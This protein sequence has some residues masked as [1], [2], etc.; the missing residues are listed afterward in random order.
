MSAGAEQNE[1][2]QRTALARQRRLAG[3]L[4]LFMAAVYVGARLIPE[5]PFWL[6]L[7]RAA[8][9]A[10]LVGGLADW[11]AVTALFRHPF[12]I[13]IPHTAIIPRNQARI[14]VALGRFVER[15][16]L[17][18]EL[19]T[20][21]LRSLDLA[22]RLGSWL[23]EPTHAYRVAARITSALPWMVHAA[24][25][26]SLRDF[27]RRALH[28]QLAQVNLAPMLGGLLELLKAGGRHQQLFDRALVLGSELLA[29]NE[30]RV[31]ALISDKSRWWVPPSID[32]NIARRLI[33]ALH[34][35]LEELA[36]HEH[37]ARRGFDAATHDFI[38]RLKHS[39]ELHTRVEA[40][41]REL[42]DSPRMQEY[43]AAV[44]EEL[45]TRIVDDAAAPDS[46]ITAALSH[47]LAALGTTLMQ[48]DAVRA[49]VNRR[50]EGLTVDFAVP[51]R[52]EIGN[53]IA[54][55]V[56]SWDTATMTDR[57]ELIVGRDLQFIRIN[58]TLVGA[59]VGVLLFL[60][61]SLLFP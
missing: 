22:S 28:E 26:R 46:R 54:E 8:S 44:W 36:D 55:V 19:L 50:I 39:P 60:G 56:N 27:A 38:E 53:F 16:F 61:S 24:D 7:V 20:Q 35:L 5:A 43:F 37:E 11:F 9:E 12:G 25:D 4:L 48:D 18:P 13:P 40:L 17:E 14:G 23:A 41:K 29:D 21:K 45:R 33:R 51:W 32:R 2:G 57:L 47:A 1:P 3:G 58:G 59:L 49:R 10:A 31:Y 34:E 6:Q 30:E 52:A 42:L 15:H